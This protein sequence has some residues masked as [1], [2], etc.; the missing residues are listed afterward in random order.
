MERT[1]ECRVERPVVKEGVR[2]GE[3]EVQPV[4][5]TVEQAVRAVV[6]SQ[7]KKKALQW[8]GFELTGDDHSMDSYASNN[9]QDGKEAVGAE[10]R[11]VSRRPT[12]R[13]PKTG[14]EASSD[15]GSDHSDSEMI[16][17]V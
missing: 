8:Q 5:S 9:V 2:D 16:S 7:K 1:T 13:K 14:I 12:R 15:E 6:K 3:E 4:A 11:G 17:S 10:P